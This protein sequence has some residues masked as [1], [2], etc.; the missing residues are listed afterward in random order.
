MIESGEEKNGDEGWWISADK[1]ERLAAGHS[2]SEGDIRIL[3]EDGFV[4]H[5]DPNDE[6]GAVYWRVSLRAKIDYLENLLGA[7][8]EEGHTTW[9]KTVVAIDFSDL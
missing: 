2:G 3:R 7:Y 8:V 1:L 9:S 5:T 6:T 4:S